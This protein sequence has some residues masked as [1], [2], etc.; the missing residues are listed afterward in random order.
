MAKSTAVIKP[1][2]GLYLD[3]PS[4][5]IPPGGLQGGDNFRV[6]QGNLT[7]LNLGW[8]A[9]NSLQLNGPARLIELFNTSEGN[10]YL[11]FGTQTDLY[12]YNNNTLAYINPI[13]TAGTVATSGATVTGSSTAWATTVSGSSWVNAKPGDQISFGATNIV[14]PTA[15]WYT[16]L[17]VNSAT[18]LTL[19]SAPPTQSPG[20]SYTLRQLF[21]GAFEDPWE[22][23]V[24]VDANVAGPGYGNGEDLIYFTNGVDTPVNWNGTSAQVN[25]LTGLGFTCKG[26]VQF[27]DMMCYLNVIYGASTLATTMINSDAGS[28][29]NAGNAS[30]GIAGQFIVQGGTDPI[31]NGFRLG[32]YLALYC[33]HTI[34]LVTATGTATTF[35]FRIAGSNKGAIGQNAIAPYATIHQFLAPDGMYYFDGSNVQPVNTHIW[36]NI[37]SSLDTKRANNIFSYL[38]EQNGEM[39]WSVPQTSDPNAGTV[40]APNTQAWTEH[41]L[42]ETAGQTQSALIASA[43]GINRP[44]STRTFPFTAVGNFINESALTWADLTSQWTSYQ[45]RWNDAFFSASF[46]LILAGDNN[47][48]IYQLNTGALGNGT[49]LN[50]YVTFG[51][52]AVI[53]GRMRGLIRRIYP[54]IQTFPQSLTVNI[55]LADFGMGPATINATF[56]FDQTMSVQGQFMVPVYRRGRYIDLGFGDALGNPWVISGYDFDVLPGGMR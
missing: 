53:D 50:S 7:N 44:Y 32:A 10:Q 33:A 8:T 55:G 35:S 36:R 51:R 19:T 4:L 13:Y 48:F 27:S 14:D 26:L 16:I 31:L 5:A 23:E 24:F 25:Q 12:S 43:M 40:S 18:S 11:I 46:P 38:D 9:F 20:T 15:T 56:S 22:T 54:F 52:R 34:I 29:S 47:G 17:T 41:Y 39:I 49:P 2:L 3:R 28:P 6:R 37:L 21:T 1:N 30:T 45:Y 42:E